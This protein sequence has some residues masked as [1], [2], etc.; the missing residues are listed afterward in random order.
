MEEKKH[1]I[2][3]WMCRCI[4]VNIIINGV[5]VLTGF[6]TKEMILPIVII[7]SVVALLDNLKRKWFLSTWYFL[8]PY[9]IRVHAVLNSCI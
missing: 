9:F 1:W 5:G 3:R 6:I 2:F 8:I 7:S 4:I